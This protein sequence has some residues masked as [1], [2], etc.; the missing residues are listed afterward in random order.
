MFKTV[1][2][3]ELVKL[4]SFHELGLPLKTVHLLKIWGVETPSEL[5]KNIF[6]LLF[7]SKDLLIVSKPGSG[8]TLSY[9]LFLLK[10]AL[11]NRAKTKNSFLSV[12]SVVILPNKA[13]VLQTHRTFSK[14]AAGLVKS[15]AMVSE[16]P[17]LEYITKLKKGVDV[18]F[19]TPGKLH[20]LLQM[21]KGKYF[22]LEETDTVV[23]DEVDT[24]FDSGFETQTKQ[25]LG[26]FRTNR[27][28]PKVL[29]FSAFLPKELETACRKQL[30]S[31][32]SVAV[33]DKEKLSSLVSSLVKEQV[34]VVVDKERKLSLLKE[35][36]KKSKKVVVFCNSQTQADSL[37]LEL[38]RTT[39]SLC[40][41]H[42]GHPV[43]KQKLREVESNK[44]VITTD[45]FGKSM[46]FFKANTVFNFDCPANREEYWSRAGRLAVFRSFGTSGFAEAKIVSVLGTEDSYGS[47]VLHKSLLAKAS[48]VKEPMFNVLLE[49]AFKENMKYKRLRGFNNRK[50]FDFSLKEKETLKSRKRALQHLGPS[51]RSFADLVV[52]E[53]CWLKSGCLLDVQ[54][55]LLKESL[56]ETFVFSTTSSETV[57]G[58]KKKLCEI[59]RQKI[60]SLDLSLFKEKVRAVFS[61]PNEETVAFTDKRTGKMVFQSCVDLGNLTQQKCWEVISKTS[62]RSLYFG[63]ETRIVFQGNLLNPNEIGYERPK[64]VVQTD[65]EE[66]VGTTKNKILNYINSL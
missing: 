11:E 36:V 62:N 57:F 28:P 16:N 44:T 34:F 47:L 59:Y 42:S 51:K 27:F 35:S 40:V 15:I 23:L 37:Y 46:V 6:H 12:N 52:M 30:N 25:L 43:S 33:F 3:T 54:T 63:E 13:L 49:K 50:G 65:D 55:V 60:G 10:K 53:E 48:A 21:G 4:E 24:L 41:F 7:T 26:R 45:G 14:L 56:R 1:P 9:L 58:L 8:K 39:D 61:G 18:I 38:K 17:N 2:K 64:L 22:S 31:A 5:Q 29:L 32:N 19:V 66:K 20:S